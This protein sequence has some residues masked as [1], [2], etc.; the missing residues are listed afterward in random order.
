MHGKHHSGI[1][2]HKALSHNRSKSDILGDLYW[3]MRTPSASAASSTRNEKASAN[4]L[5]LLLRNPPL[6][7]LIVRLLSKASTRAASWHM[8][9]PLRAHRGES[10]PMAIQPLRKP[11][12]MSRNTQLLASFPLNGA[13][14]VAN[15]YGH[16]DLALKLE[17]VLQYLAEH[18]V[19]IM[20]LQETKQDTYPSFIYNRG[21]QVHT[22]PCTS[23]SS[24][25]ILTFVRDKWRATQPDTLNEDG[26]TCWSAVS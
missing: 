20:C 2:S 18:D 8:H 12:A 24:G 19:D 7:P 1:F 3:Y 15:D 6:L 10:P 11:P 4:R 22:R 26:D 25:G 5:N 14:R 17:W 21:Y 23:R 9:G 13:K 16:P